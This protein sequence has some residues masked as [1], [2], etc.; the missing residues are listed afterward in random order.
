MGLV[1]YR[2]FRGLVLIME[3]LVHH[4]RTIRVNQIM[5]RF[6]SSNAS[7]ITMPIGFQVLTPLDR[8]I[9]LEF[10]SGTGHNSFTRTQTLGTLT[11][12]GTT[13]LR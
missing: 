7:A 9:E 11:R 2:I 13:M 8:S 1:E 3:E 12:R 10:A 4:V 5:L 6:S